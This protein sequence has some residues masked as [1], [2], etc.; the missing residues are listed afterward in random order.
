VKS[1]QTAAIVS[2]IASLGHQLN[3]PITAEGVESEQIRAELKKYGCSEAQGW[4]FG[5]AVSADS[6]RTFLGLKE[7]AQ[8]DT[9][10][11]ADDAEEGHRFTPRIRRKG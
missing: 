8:A 6:V 3:V 10:P 1:E 2:T 4:L 7:Q 5:R 9:R 11:N